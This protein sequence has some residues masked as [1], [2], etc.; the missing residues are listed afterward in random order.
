M[1]CLSFKIV[2]YQVVSTKLRFRIHTIYINLHAY[3]NIIPPSN[4]SMQSGAS[5]PLA[6]IRPSHFGGL[7][8]M[9]S[10]ILACSRITFETSGHTN[11]VRVSHARRHMLC[12]T[13]LLNA[14][15]HVEK[16]QRQTKGTRAS[17]HFWFA[18][19]EAFI[20]KLLNFVDD[21]W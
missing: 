21:I 19:N 11:M 5:P 13:G 18:F 8:T 20:K 15:S 9:K 4:E 2:K 14:G 6:F 1:Q 10:I 16:T 17:K 3:S 12:S 7:N